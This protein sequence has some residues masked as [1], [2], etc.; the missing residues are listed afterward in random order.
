MLRVGPPMIF[1]VELPSIWKACGQV[2]LRTM[3]GTGATA[4]NTPQTALPATSVV[5]L[6]V[7]TPVKVVGTRSNTFTRIKGCATVVVAGTQG[8]GTGSRHV[9]TPGTG[10]GNV[11]ATQLS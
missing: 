11:T 10:H 6:P 5:R 4:F 2:G 3:M 7:I 1:T 8:G 9:L